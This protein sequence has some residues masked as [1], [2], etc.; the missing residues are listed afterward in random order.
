MA[1]IALGKQEGDS[2]EEQIP[3]HESLCSASTAGRGRCSAGL[4]TSVKCP[5]RVQRQL[6]IS[7]R[8]PRSHRHCHRLDN[9]STQHLRRGR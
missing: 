9:H 3:A 6:A 4:P 1:E 7:W 2:G 8:V 5:A